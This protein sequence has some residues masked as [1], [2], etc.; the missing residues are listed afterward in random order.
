VRDGKHP[1]CY[2]ALFIGSRTEIMKECEY[3]VKVEHI[4]SRQDLIRRFDDT[5]LMILNMG[6]QPYTIECVG[7]NRTRGFG[8]TWCRIQIPTWCSLEIEEYRVIKTSMGGENITTYIE[9]QKEFQTGRITIMKNPFNRTPGINRIW[10]E[11]F[12]EYIDRGDVFTNSPEFNVIN[13]DNDTLLTGYVKLSFKKIVERIWRNRNQIEMPEKPKSFSTNQ[14]WKDYLLYITC[15][16][17]VITFMITI[18]RCCRKEKATTDQGNTNYG[19]EFPDYNFQR[20]NPNMQ[21]LRMQ[22]RQLNT[23]ERRRAREMEMF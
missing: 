1:D 21:S 6:S 17:S 18:A 2:L 3:V 14:G 13:V 10:S 20:G 22:Q 12:P 19:Y 15:G 4:T 7:L 5:N 9:M 8:C 11:R 23:L 16:L